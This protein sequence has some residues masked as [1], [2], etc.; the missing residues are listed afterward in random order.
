M[1]RLTWRE[2]A[3]QVGAMTSA[4]LA[5]V[6]RSHRVAICTMAKRGWARA[7]H[8]QGQTNL[9][10]KEHAGSSRMVGRVKAGS[11]EPDYSP[12]LSSVE[13]P[14]FFLRPSQLT[15]INCNNVC[16]DVERAPANFLCAGTVLGASALLGLSRVSGHTQLANVVWLRLWARL[17]PS[18]PLMSH[19]LLASSDRRECWHS[20]KQNAFSA[21]G[22]ASPYPPTL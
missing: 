3:R 10:H 13:A 9:P 22:H 6:A 2:P 20:W 8:A 19:V 4:L 11:W 16:N 17:H 14:S 21:H 15:P 5:H 1:S 12:W 7:F 18:N